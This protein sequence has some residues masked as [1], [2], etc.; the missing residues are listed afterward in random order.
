MTRVKILRIFLAIVLVLAVVGAYALA[1]GTQT[2]I[3][4]HFA[5]EGSSFAKTGTIAAAVPEILA[6]EGCSGSGSGPI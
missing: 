4:V 5:Q 2:H 6:C 1:S 3:T